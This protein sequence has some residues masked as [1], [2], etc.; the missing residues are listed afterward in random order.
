VRIGGDV[1]GSARHPAPVW[2]VR[3]RGAP[4]EIREAR[5]RFDP[6]VGVFQAGGPKGTSRRVHMSSELPSERNRVAFYDLLLG[7]RRGDGA[8][9]AL[10][11]DRARRRREDA[12]S[13]AHVN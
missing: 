6:R 13:A 7:G 5:R 3:A 2:R 12:R 9:V 10:D 11:P 4:G 1:I 8:A